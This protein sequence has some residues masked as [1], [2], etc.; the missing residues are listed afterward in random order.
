MLRRLL[1]TTGTLLAL[2]AGATAQSLNIDLNRTSGAGAG[3]PAASFGAAA[4]Q[5]GTWNA[6]G[7]GAGTTN[8]VG[9]NG[10]SAGV[11]ATVGGNGVGDNESGGA[12]P[13]DYGLLMWDYTRGITQNGEVELTLNGLD[14]GLY[15]VYVYALLPGTEGTYTDSW[16]D[17]RYHTN[18]VGVTVGNTP[19]GSEI[20]SGPATAGQFVEGA[21]HAA[22]NVLVPAGSPDVTIRVGCDLANGVAK[23]AL[24]G[25]QL[26]KYSGNR[27]YVD[28]NTPVANGDNG[29]TWTSAFGNLQT[30]LNLADVA[31][32]QVSE[33]WV[34][35]GTYYPDPNSRFATFTLQNGV[36]LIGGF[37][38]GETNVSDRDTWNQRAYLA[39][40]IGG[41][42]NGDNTY[43]IVTADGVN[44]TAV[45]DGFWISSGN[46]NGSSS[47]QIGGGLFCNEASP[48]VR[49]CT[50]IGNSATYGGAVGAQMSSPKF[51]NCL[52]INN[53]SV[54][55][56]GAICQLS[57]PNGSMRIANCEFVNNV[58]A[59]HGAGLYASGPTDLA[60]CV[61][62][63][64]SST[65]GA[66]AI[67]MSESGQSFSITNCTIT[68]N[69][70]VFSTGG[71]YF[72]AGNL[73]VSNS[74]V[75]GNS[76]NP[77]AGLNLKQQQIWGF[78]GATIQ[79]NLSC[80][81]THEANPWVGLKNIKLDPQFVDI[82]G[83]NNNQG[84]LDDDLRLL[85][86]SPAVDAGGTGVLPAD[87]CD[88]DADGNVLEFIQ[89]DLDGHNRRVDV[90]SAPDVG[91]N[92][93]PMPDMGAYE[94]QLSKL[95]DMDCDGDVD[96]FDIDPF[97]AA[98]SGEAAYLGSFP[99]CF[100]L[101]A[102]ANGDGEVDFFD[103]DPFVALIG[104]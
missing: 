23:C 61:F 82:D 14:A 97:V 20:I 10:A 78:N 66:G 44:S 4:G 31:N 26:V 24:N 81:E 33:I 67:Y 86:A 36:K 69:E 16:G 87:W 40:S 94:V 72:E 76:S 91:G 88:V 12:A 62:N 93:S 49:N 68:R 28:K 2:A 74:I 34:A 85:P 55:A 19:A 102:D 92:P 38:G 11:T 63:G 100:W 53:G 22:F 103:I 18:W 41:F 79:V 37:A 73:L 96:F 15:R 77:N 30:A 56:G 42:L 7:T 65:E 46:A 13:A 45:L 51:A 54:D 84:D 50:F 1:I 52:F 71:V 5:T 104:S 3:A 101:N 6:V 75:W 21:T 43:H 59:G 57:G 47:Y 29:L 60:N 80:V 89:I 39:G 25:V 8:L 70:S 17:P 35:D 90:A 48:T 83:A 27:V 58:S 64:N 98:L 9:L 32:G 95:G 99:S